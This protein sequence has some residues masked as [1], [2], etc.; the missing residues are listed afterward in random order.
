MRHKTTKRII[1][2]LAAAASV[3]SAA[4]ITSASYISAADQFE[5]GT[6]SDGLYY[7]LWNQDG[8]GEAAMEVGSDG[9]FSCSWEDVDNCIFRRGKKLGSVKNYQQYG[10]I[11]LDYDIDYQPQGDSAVCVYGWTE[12]PLTEYFI[13]EAWSGKMPAG[14][15]VLKE[16]VIIDG[17]EYDIYQSER[18]D[19]PSIQGLTSFTQCIS[20]R[21]DTADCNG[22]TTNLTGSVRVTKHFEAWEKAGMQTGNIYEVTLNVEGYKASGGKAKVNKNALIIGFASDYDNIHAAITPGPGLGP[23]EETSASE[24]LIYGDLDGSETVDLTDLIKLSQYLLKDIELSEAELAASDVTGD[25]VTDLSD[26]ALLKQFVM[27]DK[28]TLG[29]N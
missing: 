1:A 10:S 22:K 21:R 16:Q 12:A 7:E 29:K 4:G 15:K 3:I 9:K 6:A 18:K 20:V 11:L 28:V 2:S 5:D 13:Y 25:D 27:N 24:E 14:D 8:T 23:A 17:N 26:M 19:Q